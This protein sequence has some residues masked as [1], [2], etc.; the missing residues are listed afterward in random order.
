MIVGALVITVAGIGPLGIFAFSL[1]AI[2]VSVLSH[3]NWLL[4]AGLDRWLRM[5]L[6]TPG[7]HRIHH[8]ARQTE[9]DSN[10]GVLFSVWDRMFNSYCGSP[11]HGYRGMTLGLE[12][13]RERETQVFHRMLLNPID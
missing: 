10:Y 2:P 8:S 12:A 11:E 9:T 6:V 1:L 13:F 5:I 3:G 7:M 4:P